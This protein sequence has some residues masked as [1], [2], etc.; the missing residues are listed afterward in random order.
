MPPCAARGLCRLRLSGGSFRVAW[1]LRDHHFEQRGFHHKM[2]DFSIKPRDLPWRTM[3]SVDF[4]IKNLVIWTIKKNGIDH[5]QTC[6]SIGVFFFKWSLTYGYGSIPINS[7]FRGMNIHKSQLFW[8]E[9][10]GYKVLTNCHIRFHNRP[11]DIWMF[12]ISDVGLKWLLLGRWWSTSE[13]RVLHFGTVPLV[14]FVW[15]CPWVVG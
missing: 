12:P 6:G 2:G 5:H 13:F 14:F 11:S 15:L 3:K 8:C 1:R 9:L 4:T 7:I 10:Q